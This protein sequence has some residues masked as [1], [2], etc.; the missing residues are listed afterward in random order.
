MSRRALLV[1]LLL[2]LGTLCALWLAAGLGSR[3]GAL[4]FDPRWPGRI[5]AGAHT[6]DD[7]ILLELRLPRVIAA[8][9]VGSALAVAGLVL[10]G[11]TQNALADPYLL[12]IAGGAGLAVVLTHALPTSILAELGWWIT[13]AAAFAG[14]Q[15][16]S[17]LVLALARGAAGRRTALATVLAGLIINAFCAALMTLVLVRLDPFRTRITT[18]WLAGGIEFCTWPHLALAMLLLL[19]SLLFLRAQAHRLNAFALGE[20]G[21]AYVGVDA[22][23]LLGRVALVASLLTG[24]AVSMGGLLGF[25]GLIVPH[26]V[27]LLVGRDFRDTLPAA[28][29]AG[30]LLLLLCD[31]G[32]RLLF[33]PEETPVGV[34]TALLGC[35]LLLG[36]LRAQLRRP[37]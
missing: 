9:L 15:A 2:G 11:V 29:V 36:L 6:P 13:P 18:L 3:D 8:L 25:V 31:S 28:G 34:L 10:Q 24:L 20:V 1:C 19:P 32:A 26:V 33:L 14:A 5:F 7:N 22:E 4:V 17:L 35:P 37:T 16:A 27:R 12:G 23:R 30:A 21:A